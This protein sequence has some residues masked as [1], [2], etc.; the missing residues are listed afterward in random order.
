[1]KALTLLKKL[2]FDHVRVNHKVENISDS[3]KSCTINSIFV[4][5]KGSRTNGSKYVGEAIDKGAKTIV[6]D[7]DVGERPGINYIYV[8]NPKRALAILLYYFNI[9][10]IR[11]VKLIGVIGTNGK[12]S[13]AHNIYSMLNYY[14]KSSSLIGTDGFYLNNKRYKHNN[15]TPNIC[16]IYEYIKMSVSLRVR[17]ICMEVS[18]VAVAELRCHMLPFKMLIFTNFSEDHLDYHKTIDSYYKNK[19][20]PF[21]E[22]AND[23]YAII[24]KDDIRY[25]EIIKHI[26]GR[27]VSYSIK[28]KSMYQA[29]NIN[30]QPNSISFRAN[31]ALYKCHMIGEFNV[32]NLLPLLF[33]KDYFNI[34]SES[35]KRFL[36][37]HKPLK[38]RMD[39]IRY[40]LSHIII[41][42]AHT[43]S[44]VAS[45]IDT[46]KSLPHKR[47]YVVIGC[48][49]NRE[50][51]KREK[52]GR[53]LS[54]NDV[55]IILTSDNPRFENPLDIIAD[56]VKGINIPYVIIENRRKAIAY[57][58]DKLKDDDYLL[59]LGK[60]NEDYIEIYGN[61]Y[62][63]NDYDVINELIS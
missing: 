18:S 58:I 22:L 29:Y 51:E 57:A 13:T 32:Y 60:G 28:S 24:N 45:V 26:K 40:N 48:G 14:H 56:I 21:I 4:A 39:V 61:K 36:A 52:I 47:I 7:E 8:D 2:G 54:D 20:L 37:N 38:G 12:S 55:S 49:G 50:K 17:Y 63:Y 35:F 30:L 53:I 6:L 3:S 25:S 34:S 41:D 59:V 27:V 31:N 1:M 43:E 11:R 62:L 15:T 44:G 33:F 16:T 19:E 5:I 9:K 23:S 46:V 42:Y 10:Y